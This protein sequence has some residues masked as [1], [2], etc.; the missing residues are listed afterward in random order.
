MRVLMIDDHALFRMGLSELLQRR[1]I[2]V[3]A[4]L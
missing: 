2:E 1:G 4:A 3:V